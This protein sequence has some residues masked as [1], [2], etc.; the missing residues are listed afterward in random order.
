MAVMKAKIEG[1]HVNIRVFCDNA[2][3]NNEEFLLCDFIQKEFHLEVL[4]RINFPRWQQFFS[5]FYEANYRT[6][7]P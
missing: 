4:F 1:G 2:K 3:G 7:V 5:Y 6:E